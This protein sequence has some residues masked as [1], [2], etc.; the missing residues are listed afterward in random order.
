MF[1]LAAGDFAVTVLTRVSELPPVALV[2]TD[3]FLGGRTGL[4][5]LARLINAVCGGVRI[6]LSLPGD[7]SLTKGRTFC[8]ESYFFIISY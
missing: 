2:C 3:F 6:E 1:S 7:R 5:L 4:I 8:G